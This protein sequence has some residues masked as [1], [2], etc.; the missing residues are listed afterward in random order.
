MFSS[1]LLVKITS[2]LLVKIALIKS[3]L[4]VKITSCF[5]EGNRYK[6]AAVFVAI[7]PWRK[8]LQVILSV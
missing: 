4:L 7:S 5:Y 6:F 8:L 2:N 3:Y 1:Y